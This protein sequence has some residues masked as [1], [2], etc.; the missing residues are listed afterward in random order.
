MKKAYWIWYNGDF[1]LYH[2]L[3]LHTRRE[4]YGFQ[5]P[6]FW[7][8]S[9]PY[10]TVRF[11]TSFNAKT[12]TSI[13]AVSKGIGFIKIDEISYPLNTDVKVGVGEHS[14]EIDIM[15]IDTFP[16]VYVESEYLVTDKSWTASNLSGNRM[17]AGCSEQYTAKDSDP[18]IFAFSYESVMPKI[19]N[20]TK[21]DTGVLYDFGR[22]LFAI[23]HIEG[24]SPDAALLVSYGESAEEACEPSESLIRETVTGSDSYTLVARAFRYVH[25]TDES[26]RQSAPLTVWADYEYLPLSDKASF[27]CDRRAVKRIWDVCSYTFHLNSREF[28]LDGIKRDRWVWSG[29]AYQSYMANLYLFFDPDITRRTIIALLGKPPYEQPINSISDYSMYLIIAAYEYYFATGDCE[30]VRNYYSR[31]KALYDFTASRTNSEGYIDQIGEDWIFIDWS[32]MDKG[33]ALCAEQI[34]F[35]KCTGAMADLSELCGLDGDS[36]R[37]EAERFKRKIM[38]DYWKE[39][40]GAFVDCYTTGKE[41][42]TR[43]ANIFAILFDFVSE[44]RAKKILR[45]VLEND[46]VNHITT[47]YFEFFQ[48]CALCKMGRLRKAQK[49][50]ESYWGAMLKLGATT[51]WEQYI[52]ERKGIEHYEMY[53]MKYGCSHCHAW[54]SG[55]IYLLGRYALGVYPTSVAYKTFTVEPSLG[56]YKNMKGTVPISET[57]TVSVTVDAHT[58]SVSATRGGGTLVL[59]GKS[60]KIPV[61]ES[62]TVEY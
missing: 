34:L 48:L 53:G 12:E 16:S 15:N 49:K 3:K 44:K 31:L 55:P 51:I 11:S 26:S 27:E 14:V 2:S 60:Y 29:D 18:A 43:H 32:D 25:I 24:A 42:V 54:G 21:T 39:A 45:H 9:V 35:W 46:A 30:F 47:P 56:I 20:G 6:P 33:G 5:Y 28:F 4:Q 38:K 59:G 7:K 57:D 61:G 41:N 8:L 58:C 1:E 52:P 36:Y 50:I 40:R 62:L 23:I 37:K 22:E 10:P 17:P 19:K 13:Q